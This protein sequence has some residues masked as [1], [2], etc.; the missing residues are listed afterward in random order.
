MGK[1]PTSH[2]N[3]HSLT[4]LGLRVKNQGVKLIVDCHQ[5][6]LKS[7]LWSPLTN[8]GCH[9]VEFSILIRIG[10]TNTDYISLDESI[11]VTVSE[12]FDLLLEESLE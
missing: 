7:L 9:L 5:W 1:V 4:I 2:D 6:P 3:Y 11:R 12:L 10:N 8:L